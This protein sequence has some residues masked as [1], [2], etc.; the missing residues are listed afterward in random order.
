MSS[1]PHI[2]RDLP[3]KE[4]EALLRGAGRYVADIALPADALTLAFVRSD[5]PAARVRVETGAARARPGVAAVLTAADL[6]PTGALAVNPLMPLRAAPDWPILA[7]GRVEAVGQPVAAVLAEGRAAARDAAEAVEVAYEPEA[8]PPPETVAERAWRS[9]DAEAGFARAAHVVEAEIRHPRLAPA[10]MEPRAIAV[11]YHAARDAVTVWSATQTPHRARDSF[12]AI[13]Q[14][15]PGRIRVIA[16]DVGGAFGMKASVYPEEVLAVWAALHLKRS[17]RW[18]ATRSE[19]FLSATHG[20][21]LSTRGRLGVDAEGRFLALEAEAVGET[22]HWL[23]TSALVPPLNA[24][25]VLPSGY[26]VA[27][28]D[29]RAAARRSAAPPV[30]IYRGAGRPEGIL[31]ME[32]LVDAAAARTGLDRMEI[33]RRNLLP[34]ERLPREMPAGGALDSGDYPGLLA[35]LEPAWR[36]ALAWRD[37]AR[38]AGGC[39]GAGLAFYVEPSGEGWESARVTLAEDGGLHVASGSSAQGQGRATTLAQI[40]ADAAGVPYE[41]V[42]VAFG[43][44]ATC[45]EGIGAVASRS[46]SIGGS[47]VWEAARRVAERRAAGAALPITEELRYET[48]GQAW[49]HGACLARLSVDVETGAP[50]LHALSCID[51]AG[52]IVNPALA[53]AQIRGGLA[54]GVGEA[55]M[56]AVRLDADGQVLT[57]SFLDYAMPRAADMPAVALDA[58]ESPSP[59]N[60]L[61]A[62][63]LGEGGTIAAPPAILSA[64]L[65]ALAP[66]GVRD[67]QPPLTSQTLWQAI[68]EAT[69]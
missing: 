4:G 24:A 50:S 42:T 46:T 59:L 63:G 22:G 29:L 57:G 35:R 8:P 7:P 28:L 12:A 44:T 26:D 32:R 60:A 3:R 52:R 40:A 15:D 53:E 23:A 37:A 11:E 58:M 39:A 56:E 34:P 2:G 62:K 38:A 31:L 54:Q 65:D 30:S 55:L 68:R 66:F 1:A 25:R 14:V 6:P 19:E 18:V 49:G 5:L 10:P 51:D 69:A 45:P 48:G 47:A 13:L 36:A 67:L 17:V 27:A 9:G 61:G 20:R 41:A 21:G 43:D 64:A 33:R 16:P